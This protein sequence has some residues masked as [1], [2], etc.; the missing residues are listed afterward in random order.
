MAVISSTDSFTLYTGEPDTYH[1]R[2]KFVQGNNESPYAQTNQVEII[3]YK[4]VYLPL[5]LK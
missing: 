1:F 5:V 4:I 2:L 3:D